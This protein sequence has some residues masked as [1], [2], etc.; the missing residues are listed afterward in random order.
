MAQKIKN[1]SATNFNEWSLTYNCIIFGLA[2]EKVEA[3]EQKAVV[4]VATVVL[5]GLN[6]GETRSGREAPT[7]V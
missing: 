1:T 5:A 2:V 6:C 3:C 4:P 7:Q